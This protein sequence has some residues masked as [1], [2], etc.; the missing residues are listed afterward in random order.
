MRKEKREELK[1]RILDHKL[2]NDNPCESIFANR[3][4]NTAKYNAYISINEICFGCLLTIL[5]IATPVFVWPL[6][7]LITVPTFLVST[8]CSLAAHEQLKG[9]KKYGKR[10]GLNLRETF[11]SFTDKKLFELMATN[12]NDLLKE[13]AIPETPYEPKQP[14]YS[15]S[16]EELFGKQTTNETISQDDKKQPTTSQKETETQDEEFERG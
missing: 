11:K 16:D 3:D 7:L 2:N 5:G 4:A 8:L 1:K 14:I 12:K 9:T 6:G 15:L 13:N 10:Y